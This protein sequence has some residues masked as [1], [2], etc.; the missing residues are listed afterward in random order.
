MRKIQQGFTLIELMIVVAII[1]I[2]AAIAIPQYQDYIV[3]SRLAKV[4]AALGP[5]KLAVAE[6]A[7]FNGG[8]LT[9]LTA[10]NWFDPQT[11][12]GLG[13]SNT[14]GATSPT[15]TNEIGRYQLAA[16]TGA[17]TLTLRNIGACANGNTLIATPVANADATVMTWGYTG[18]VITAQAN[19]VCPKEIAKWR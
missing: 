4:N 1:G 16:T 6:F 17:I 12:G 15:L 2:L 3:R 9:T 7:Q 18:T 19:S 11:S 5:I 13:M 10:D 8:V 14:G